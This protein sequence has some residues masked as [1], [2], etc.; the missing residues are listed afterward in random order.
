M[1]IR[2]ATIDDVPAFDR[3]R[4]ATF[5]WHTAS[6]ASQLKRFQSSPPEAR[7]RRLSAE[8]DGAVVGMAMSSIQ[9]NTPEAGVGFVFLA[10]HP[11]ARGAGVGSALLAQAEQHLRSLNLRRMVSSAVGGTPAIGWA[12]K[13]GWRAGASSQFSAVDPRQLPPMPETPPGVRIVD[14]ADVDPR[15]LYDV[16]MAASADHPGDVAFGGLPYELWYERLY[17]DPDVRRDLSQVAL[18]DGKPVAFTLLEA[19]LDL[20]RAW[21]GGTATLAAHRGRGLAKLL[22]SVCLRKAAAAGVTQAI[23]ANHLT[24]TP[25]L[26]VNDWLGYRVAASE[27]S[28]LK[29]LDDIADD[30]DGGRS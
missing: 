21:T 28:M 23:T 5:S 8:V 30:H 12:E 22:K 16:D 11:T 19:N 15:A 17:R 26:A 3:I 6:L 7:M 14:V 18:V 24:N 1:L 27:V 13:R 25:M 20:G 29:G 10:V 4:Q 9:L 2:E